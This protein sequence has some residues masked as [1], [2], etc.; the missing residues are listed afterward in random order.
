MG[1]ELENQVGWVIVK[2]GYR[3]HKGDQFF[4]EFLVDPL[5]GLFIVLLCKDAEMAVLKR[6]NSRFSWLFID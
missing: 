6:D 4:L 1:L 2:I 3:S 5:Q